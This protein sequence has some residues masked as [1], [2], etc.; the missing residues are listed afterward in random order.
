M[1]TV[2]FATSSANRAL[3]GFESKRP[4]A[5]AKGG[6]EGGREGACRE[7]GVGVVK[8]EEAVVEGIDSR[9]RRKPR[10]GSSLKLVGGL[11]FGWSGVCCC[12]CL[13]KKKSR[14][15]AAVL[16]GNGKPG[17]KGTEWGRR[18]RVWKGWVGM[19]RLV[20]EDWTVKAWLVAQDESPGQQPQ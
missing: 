20:R 12:C 15:R 16:R 6:R 5:R 17:I 13:L 14:W 10:R 3:G 2:E 4:M 7:C 19:L 1:F 18:R 8:C 11:C 9:L